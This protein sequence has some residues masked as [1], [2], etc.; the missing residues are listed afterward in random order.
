MLNKKFN[1]E[2]DLFTTAF[3]ILVSIG[4]FSLTYNSNSSNE[5]AVAIESSASIAPIATQ[6]ANKIA[7][8]IKAEKKEAKNAAS[9]PKAEKVREIAAVE[10]GAAE[11]IN[12]RALRDLKALTDKINNKA[13]SVVVYYDDAGPIEKLH[14]NVD[15]ML[16]TDRR[17]R[18]SSEKSQ[19]VS[20]AIIAFSIGKKVAAYINYNSSVPENHII[21]VEKYIQSYNNLKVER[22]LLTTAPD[23]LELTLEVQ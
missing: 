22:R 6:V 7:K 15:F 12:D 19:L 5:A 18:I 2:D 10:P 13:G 3:L 20:P 17:P 21:A 8:D 16:L 14:I 11:K 4:W 23:Q 9:Q 1:F